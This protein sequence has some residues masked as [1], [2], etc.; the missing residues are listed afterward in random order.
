ME[1]IHCCPASEQSAWLWLL[2]HNCPHPP[3]APSWLALAMILPCSLRHPPPCDRLQRIPQHRRQLLAPFLCSAQDSGTRF[4]TQIEPLRQRPRLQDIRQRTHGDGAGPL[5]TTVRPAPGRQTHTPMP[6]TP[7]G[8]HQNP[9]L[10]LMTG[11][12]GRFPRQSIEAAD[13]ERSQE[14]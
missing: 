4:L 3:G 13:V 14:M 5:R 11:R 7:R 9:F 8:R 10:R 1:P 2:E 6:P 12:R